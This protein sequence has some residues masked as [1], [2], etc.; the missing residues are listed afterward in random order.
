MFNLKDIKWNKKTNWQGIQ[1]WETVENIPLA[2]KQQLGLKVI[3]QGNKIK[4]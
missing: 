2:L 3:Y 1:G 4:K